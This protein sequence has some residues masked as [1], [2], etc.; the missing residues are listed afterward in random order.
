MQMDVKEGEKPE[1]YLEPLK[2]ALSRIHHGESGL[3]YKSRQGFGRVKITGR[4]RTYEKPHLLD[5]LDFSWDEGM[6]N[7]VTTKLELPKISDSDYWW[8]T[9][10]AIQNSPLCIRQYS[11]EMKDHAYDYRHMHSGDNAFIPGTSWAGALRDSCGKIL[12]KLTMMEPDA[13]LAIRLLFGHVISKLIMDAGDQDEVRTAFP[14][15]C[16]VGESTLENGWDFTLTRTKINRF[17]GGVAK[18]ALF[19]EQVHVGADTKLRIGVQKN[20]DL[21]WAVGL[22]LLAI[23][24]FRYG[25]MPLGGSVGIGRGLFN[26]DQKDILLDGVTITDDKR[27]EFYKKLRLFVENPRFPDAYAQIS[28]VE[29]V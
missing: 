5:S 4:L 22:L 26:V 13:T 8:I 3:G 19:T 20:E 25:M 2:E 10:N 1:D 12:L 16:M 18:G 7:D 9:V 6:G 15:H 29:E 17:T 28:K 23:E 11:A 14:S 27:R 21:E 24:D